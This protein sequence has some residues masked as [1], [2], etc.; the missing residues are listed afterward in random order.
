MFSCSEV[1]DE[2]FILC[3]RIFININVLSQKAFQFNFTTYVF[4]Q[5]GQVT[6]ESID[7]IVADWLENH[8]WVWLL[9]SSPSVKCSMNYSCAFGRWRELNESPG[10][11]AIAHTHEVKLAAVGGRAK[12]PQTDMMSGA[13]IDLDSPTPVTI[14]FPGTRLVSFNYNLAMELFLVNQRGCGRR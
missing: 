2:S 9:Y 10:L 5:W 6:D 1:T 7:Q 8:T 13:V 14:F 11:A 3:K 4:S 12:E